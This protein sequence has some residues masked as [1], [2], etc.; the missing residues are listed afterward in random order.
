MLEAEA[1]D[2]T[3]PD[4]AVP[5]MTL[6]DR[7]LGNILIGI[8]DPQAV[9]DRHRSGVVPGDDETGLDADDRNLITAARANRK[10]I[11]VHR[12]G[13]HAVEPN[14]VDRL[15]FGKK[16]VG[17][18]PP[19]RKDLNRVAG[20]KI[21]KQND[22]GAVS[23]RNHAPVPQA[24]GPGSGPGRGAV[25][26]VKRTA[27]GDQRP[28]HMV[29]MALLVDIQGV[30]IIR[31]KGNEAR[32]ILVED[33]RQRMHVLGYGPLA[34]EDRHA[35]PDFLQ[36]LGGGCGFV[37]GADAGGQVAVQIIAA[38]QRR[39]AVDMAVLKCGQ[40]VEDIG[41]GVQDAGKIHELGKTDDMGIVPERQK[42]VDL[43]LRPGRLEGGCGN[44]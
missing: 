17:D 39:M 37:I 1:G 19:R 13:L 4:I 26:V 36:S 24:E 25:N 29:Q 27:K 44:A 30:S 42:V 22:V 2:E 14:R 43:Q 12:P 10:R 28:D 38:N 31:A 23:G 5:A 20:C 21:G 16:F 3:Q 6:D 41:I 8:G 40:F 15:P 35:F 34:D 9:G 33:I 32:R 7:H 11:G 18:R